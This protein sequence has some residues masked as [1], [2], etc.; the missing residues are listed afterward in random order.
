MRR[1]LAMLLAVLM[2]SAAC[3]KTE[4]KSSYAD[5]TAEELKKSI[6]SDYS[7]GDGSLTDQILEQLDCLED[8]DA[9]EGAV[10]KELMA[11]WE[12]INTSMEIHSGICP[13]GLD[14]G[15]SMCIVVM[16]YQLNPDGSMQEEL[17]DR[18]ETALACAELYPHA[19]IALTGGATASKNKDATEAGAMA[20]WLME[21]GIAPERIITETESLSTAQN[22][23]YT[24]ALLREA[25]LDGCSLV[26]VTSRY[27]IRLSCLVFMTQLLLS[28][29]RSEI[30]SNAVCEIPGGTE[31]GL[32]S[33]ASAVSMI[34]SAEDYR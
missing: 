16:G 1:V 2:L 33:Q 29:S 22:A 27:H 12:E 17:V 32:S 26:I 23:L 20:E 30:I 11:N 9:G 15:S 24:C 5:Y 25:G 10:W 19:Y 4:E 3:G 7:A 18:L 31:A 6:L 8:L 34:L 21:Q 28:D 14:D 13:E